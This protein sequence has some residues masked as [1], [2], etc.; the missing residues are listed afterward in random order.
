ENRAARARILAQKGLR[1]IVL[2]EEAYGA[3]GLDYARLPFA[4]LIAE[5]QHFDDGTGV[6]VWVLQP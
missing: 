3:A 4:E 1:F 2:D 5:E 6:T